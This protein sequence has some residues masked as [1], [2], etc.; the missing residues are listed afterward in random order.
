M[1]LTPTAPCGKAQHLA[2]TD[3]VLTLV[4]DDKCSWYTLLSIK[5]KGCNE[6]FKLKKQWFI[7]KHTFNDY[8]CDISMKEAWWRTVELQVYMNLYGQ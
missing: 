8:R 7:W 5:S 1:E 3:E 6:I 2:S 4:S